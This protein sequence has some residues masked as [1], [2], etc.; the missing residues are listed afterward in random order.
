[1]GKISIA[2]NIGSQ[3]VGHRVRGIGFH[4]QKLVEY[5]KKSKDLSVSEIDLSKSTNKYDLYCYP[6]FNP[7]F[8]SLPLRKKGKTVLTIHDLIY[9]IYPDKYPSGIKGKLIF[10]I[11]K[12]LVKRVDAIITIS[13][14]SKKDICRFLKINP[15]KVHVVY[16]AAGENFKKIED[17]EKLQEVKNKYRL[18]DK[19][20]LYLG[21]VNYNKNLITLADACKL[22]NLPLVIVGKQ[23]ADE[24]IDIN[25]PENIPFEKFLEKYEKDKD[26]LRIGYVSDGELPCLFSLASVYCQPSFYEGFGLPV[27]QAFSC[28]LPV[29]ISKTQA[30][31]EVAEDAAL[32]ADPKE[33]K[34]VADKITKVLEDSIL[35][36]SLIQKGFK[37]AKNFSWEKCARETID[38]YKKVLGK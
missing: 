14:T 17:K 10:E 36:E 32:I 9:L 13:E 12:I 6:S 22:A 27:V 8:L 30:L 34:D 38:V 25:H 18:P 24:N 2:I 28:G 1:M 21:D 37:R 33:A 35:R 5:L 29:V 11:Q 3:A 7:Y 23:A 15:N 4:T 26:I 16:P 20:V 19:Y 31:V